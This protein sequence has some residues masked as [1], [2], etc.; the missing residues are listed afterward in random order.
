MN[1]CF[2]QPLGSISPL[3]VPN[4]ELACLLRRFVYEYHIHGHASQWSSPNYVYSLSEQFIDIKCQHDA[5]KLL[6]DESDRIPY[7]IIW[8]RTSPNDQL[9]KCLTSA[10]DSLEI[11]EDRTV[12]LNYLNSIDRSRL[13]V[14]M[15]VRSEDATFECKNVRAIYRTDSYQNVNRL[16]LQIRNDVRSDTT[17]PIRPIE[18]SARR[19]SEKYAP[20]VS[21]MTHLDLHLALSRNADNR[22]ETKNEMLRSCRLMYRNNEAEL[23]R[24]D[25]FDKKYT[26]DPDSGK[27]KAIFW[28][29]RKYKHLTTV[30]F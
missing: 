21:L 12:C 7:K 15:I 28:Y 16:I 18:R 14:Y 22:M 6:L 1:Y 20:F 9:E 11:Y 30:Y 17:S 5:K 25:E 10:F 26:H 8:L 3:A 13:T 27:G 23:N 19:L 24:I 4:S 2:S 29:T